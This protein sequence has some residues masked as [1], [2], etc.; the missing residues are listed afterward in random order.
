MNPV[1]YSSVKDYYETPPEIFDPLNERFNF[2]LDPCCQ[3]STA[4]AKKFYTKE[5]NGL[6]QDWGGETVFVNPPYG[7][8]LPKWVEKCYNEAQ[9]ENTTVVMLIPARPD[10]RYFHKFIYHN[11]KEFTFIKGRVKFLLNG[12]RTKHAAPFPSMTVV[13]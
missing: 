4:K 13:F 9:K 12:E 1:H 3:E 6:K 7:R 5:D 8:A 2:T 11:S 10:T